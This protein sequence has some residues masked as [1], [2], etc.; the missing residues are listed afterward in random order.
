MFEPGYGGGA[1]LVE[2]LAGAGD[3]L[4][5]LRVLAPSDEFPGWFGICTAWLFTFT[6]IFNGTAPVGI[7]G[8]AGTGGP[9]GVGPPTGDGTGP[10]ALL[11]MYSICGTGAPFIPEELATVVEALELELVPVLVLVLVLVV[12]VVVLVPLSLAL[13]VLCPALEFLSPVTGVLDLLPEAAVSLEPFPVDVVL[14]LSTIEFVTVSAPA[15]LDGGSAALSPPPPPS[16]T[17][18][19]SGSAVVL[20]D[21]DVDDDDDV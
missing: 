1:L 9:T 19:V 17:P 13:S 18:L 4:D 12:L 21:D 11:F 8:P 14:V 3:V 15:A 7:G 20:V 5:T 2:G 16:A 10:R 6:N